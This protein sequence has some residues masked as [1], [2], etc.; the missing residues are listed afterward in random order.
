MKT[1]LLSV[2]L[3]VSLAG[4]VDIHAQ[5]VGDVDGNRKVD[6]KDL[7]FL[8]DR[9]L[10]PSCLAPD[11]EADLDGVPGVNMSDVAVL[12]E[13]WGKD[14]SQITLVIN[15]FM[16][17][18]DRFIQDPNGDYQDWIEIYNYGDYTVDIGGMYLTDDVN[19]AN[20][21]CYIPDN[22]PEKT[23][24]G[25]S[26]YLLIWADSELSEEG[27]HVDFALDAGGG[28]D[29]GLFDT[30]GTLID[31]ITDF[32]ALGGDNSFG[33]YPNGSGP[34]RFFFHDTNMPPT[35]GTSNGGASAVDVV[36]NEIMYHPYHSAENPIEPEDMRAEYI[37]LFNRESEDVNLA[38]WRITDGVD[39]AF[40]NDVTIGAGGYLVVAADV[41]TFKA[42]YPG[43]TNMVGGWDGRL[44]NSGEVIELINEMRVNIDRLRY[45]DEG[46][47]AVRVEGPLDNNHRGWV[48]FDEHDGG[49]KSLELVNPA[50]PNEYGQNWEASLNNGGTPGA[51]N[52]VVYYDIAPMILDV[53]HRPVIPRS[54]EP[55]TVSARIL[56]ELATGI[57]VTL[58]YRV[59]GATSFVTLTMFDDATHGDERAGD[60][61]YA[62]QISARPNDT[63]IEFYIEASDA[64]ANS[65]T[66]P[67][68]S[69]VGSTPQQVTN[70]LYQV[71]DSFDPNAKWA[72]G[73]QP[74][75][76]LI[77]TGAEWTELEYIG[78]HRPDCESYAQMNATFISTDG[79]DTK[80]RYNVGVR[81][82][83][84]GSR[85][86]PPNNY[87]VNF[88]HDR[89]WKDVTAI[90]LNTK[91][92]YLQ[93]IGN[94]IF[95]MSG[96]A[97]CETTAVQ[98]RIN[99]Q[100]LA[101]PGDEMYGSY[102]HVEVV[103][104]DFANNHFPDDDAGNVYKCMWT[105][106][107]SVAAD[108]KYEGTD[109][110]AY[111]DTYFKQTNVAEDDWSDLIGLT[112]ALSENTPDEIYVEEV[113]RVINVEQWLRLIAA[114]TLVSNNETTLAIGQGD[115]YYMYCGLEDPR[116]VLVQ[117]DLD[118]L[119]GIG[120]NPD[121]SAVTRSIFRATTLATMKRFL[122]HPQFV[123]RYYWHLRDLIE[124]TFS[125]ERF[126][127]FIDKLVGDYVP[128]SKLNQIKN[129]IPARNAYVL[130]VIPSEFTINTNLSQSYGY[131]ETDVDVAVISGTADAVET[132]SVLVNGQPAYWV[133]L[134][135]EWSFGE[136]NGV[137][138]KDVTL[139]PI[140]TTASYHVPIISDAGTDW[141][142]VDFNDT[143]WDTG[144]TG[145]AFGL[146]RLPRVA[147]NDCVYQSSHP[148]IADNVTT[149]GIGSG[150]IGSTSGPLLDQA[151]GDNMGVTVTLTENGVVHWQ[152][153]PDSGGSDCAPGTDAYNTFSGIADMTGVI[154]YGNDYGWWVDLTFTGL[155]PTT[156]YTFA[157][158]AARCNYTNRLTIYTITGADTY[159]NASTSGVDVLAENK[160]RFNTG[161]NY[162]EG[163][164]ARW[165]GITAADG[166]F[167][168]RAE[169][170]P[171]ST[172][173]Y[174][175]YS[176]DVFKLDGAFSGTDVQGDMLGVNASLWTRIEFDV[177]EDPTLFNTLKLRMKYEDGFVAYLNG[178]EV[179]S[180]NAPSS[181]EW[182]STA[183]S[184]RP[185]GD[186]LAFEEINL[187]AFLHLLQPGLNVLAIHGLNDNKDNGD[188]LIL[189]ELVAGS[190]VYPVNG[191][192]LNPG[193]NRVFVQ[194]FDGPDGTG[195]E[196]ESGFVD[197][198]YNDGDDVDIFGTLATNATLDA[199]SGPWHV[200]GDIVVPAGIT[201]TIE[202]GTTLFFEPGTGITV[203][204]GGRLVAEGAQYQRI[205]LTRVPGSN[206]NWDGVK[207][208]H[209]LEDNRL[210]FIDHEFGDNQGES[211][212]VQYSRVLIDNV[213]WAETN[214]RVLN[215]DHP[216]VICRNSVF[217]SISS[218]EP[219]HGVGLGGSEQIIFDGCIFG[220]ATGYN[221]VIDFTGGQRPGP[222]FQVYNSIFLGGG[223]DGPDLDGTD[224]HIEGNIFMNFHHEPGSD[225][226]S[227]AVATGQDG[228]RISVINVARNIFLNN[229]HCVLLKEDC[230][231]RAQNN[232][233]VN[234]D[235]AVIS[236]GEPYRN[237][238][239]PPGGGVDMEGNIFWNNAEMF[240]HFFQEPLPAYGPTGEVIINSSIL[241]SQW[242][243]LGQNNI[244]AAP[245]FVDP[246]SDYHLKSMSPAIGTGPW[247]FDMGAYVPAGAAICGEPDEI[248]YRTN[249]TLTVGGPGITDY[250]YCINDPNG[251]WSEE[252]SVDEP[253]E[254][255]GLVDGHSYTVYAI[256]KNSADLWQSED[257][258][259]TSRTW[260][261]DTS[262]RRLVINEVLARN[263]EAVDHNGTNPDMIELYY[264]G[265]ASLDLADMSISDNS[266]KPR[267]FV[268]LEGTIIEPNE[269]LVLYAD[270]N[271][272]TP[273]IH[274]G[275]GLDGE[276]EDIYLYDSPSVGGELLDS[277]EFGLQIPDLSIGR[278]GYDGR[279]TL[280]QPTFGRANIAQ[281]LG[282]PAVLKI[283]EWFTNS[284]MLSENNFIELYNPQ[285]FPVNL[286]GLFLTDNPV[287]KPDKHQI[288]PLSFVPG[289]GMAVLIA[290]SDPKQGLNHLNFNLSAEQEIIALYDPDLNEIDKVIY[291]PQT[292]DVSQGRV[293]DGAD[294][295]AFCEPPTPGMSNIDTILINEALA[296]SPPGDTDWIELYN[297]TDKTINIGGWFLSDNSGNR[298]KYEIAEGTTIE[299]NDYIVFYEDVNFGN[300]NDPGCHMPFALS[301]NGETVCLSSGLDGV[302]TGYYKEQNFGASQTGVSF[303]RYLTS[304]GRYDFVAMDS[305]T[306]WQP[307][308]NPKVGP[309]VINEIMYNP[310]LPD[311][312]SYDNEEYEYIE[313][314]NITGTLVTLYRTDKLTPWKFTDGIDYTFSA[315]HYA[316]IPADGYLM[317]VKDLVAFI[318]RYGSMPGNVPVLEGYD[319]WL[320]NDGEKVQISMPGDLNSDL[321]RQYICIDRVRYYDKAPWP[322]EADG[323]GKSLSRKVANHYGNDVANWE[324]AAPSPG[325][326]NPY[327]L[328]P[329]LA[330]NPSPYDGATNINA[331]ADLSWTAGSDAT[332]HD[333]YFGTSNPPPFIG[334]QTAAT[335][336]PGTMTNI[337]TYYWCI[338]SV[339]F[340][341]KTTG[342]VWHFTTWNPPPPP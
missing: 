193:I 138:V 74:I 125:P 245:I 82:R 234:T 259:S 25:P 160:V 215:I 287:T 19:D 317:V 83:G 2:V 129:F 50:L 73:S 298:M 107:A 10:D 324:A 64:G 77:M 53:K 39:F 309:V 65:R 187:A 1:L 202:P 190:T 147:Y 20:Q 290:D 127:P 307:N 268:F 201:L 112:Y 288:A 46:D 157:T 4:S 118:C 186:A 24:I 135:G 152:P 271:P 86:D 180:R 11:C 161:D 62:A 210:C 223:D 93:L 141:T 35:P 22:C 111:R 136:S 269:Y 18:N 91:Y 14:Q 302:L 172:D 275:F 300:T 244:D 48:W 148:Y 116:F 80:L 140:G 51:I 233:F 304:T 182:N 151:T 97:Q 325:V 295:Y 149:Y 230:F 13:N 334:N 267:K 280:T 130:S 6:W 231:M 41:N 115:D 153:D 292:A 291:G 265:P 92:T 251:P 21:W 255:T 283:N 337:T 242:H 72:P 303:G 98:V 306:P 239:R 250:K 277:V 332:S 318:T 264:D 301:E 150:Y 158:S 17:E 78:S 314:H 256:G 142:A 159:T 29:V 243:Y 185:I 174:K 273:G 279:W 197:I 179:A 312:S 8:A 342:T 137:P 16:A 71:D 305:N 282:D 90:N 124:T 276:S 9:W 173:G 156:E 15:E 87:R 7:T 278:V 166:S 336:D 311:G 44:S 3:I 340:W 247:G 213:V 238:P 63:I 225:S 154:Y 217:P 211:T 169:P 126:G 297:T 58:H 310:D 323:L 132:H 117:H 67:A 133:P 284:D 81:N 316:T 281:P 99:G 123:S 232:V 296:H 110:D 85:D 335:F 38:G 155:E 120:D 224:A 163:Y 207:F 34:W 270:D 165:T 94:S 203:Q 221:D 100:N 178:Q 168:V 219:L 66:L 338:D 222:I 33:R 134:D 253:V 60:G 262:H 326:A 212:D 294:T 61:I 329:G 322:I 47:W 121:P 257:T 5:I 205:R 95:R 240:E 328:L 272:I 192:A 266:D 188:F 164:V 84:H 114:N 143:G 237:P 235:I 162:N 26:S 69:I 258:A 113:N 341:G 254:L 286:G 108:L 199:A 261:V 236:F 12:A 177:V 181:V 171:N 289:V 204:Q 189:P 104:G 43:V 96:L 218:T 122:E 36:I 196:M 226:T 227:N 200:T 31:S 37:E 54:T 208:D 198:W 102:V 30:D 88:P 101:V 216:T 176:F 293:P 55:V 42:R 330:S 184:N 319:G 339:N 333:V 241:P 131:Y 315:T 263:V 167:K 70:L 57:T 214:T 103:D 106:S 260:T 89:S 327:I 119:F 28:E 59:D 249:A 175:A 248:T 246:N 308:A 229:G 68:P 128:T 105:G 320:S 49:G 75:Y 23:T 313:L 209:T 321:E 274:L 285:A 79:V 52:S 144:P 145:L 56:D 194:T 40:P 299:P 76:Y 45:A 191:V 146:G 32:P 27:L 252:R 206:S 228:G 139:V 220:S 183:D 170:D 331:T 195:S 109:P